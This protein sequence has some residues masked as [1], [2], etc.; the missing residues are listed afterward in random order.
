MDADKKTGS[1]GKLNK[2][3]R[4]TVCILLTILLTAWGFVHLSYMCRGYDKLMTFYGMEK[5][6]CDTV[7]IGTSTTFSGIMPMDLY[8]QQ[9]I[10]SCI[11]A[12]NMQFENSLK[13]SIR[14]VLK[15]QKPK[16]LVID[17]A[18]FVSGHHPAARGEDWHPENREL[19]IKFN[20]DSMK[21]SPGRAALVH[22]I[23][24]AVDADLPRRIY[25][26]LD[27]SRYHTNTPD[28]KHFDNAQYDIGK[29]FQYLSHDAGGKTVPE[30]LGADD[31]SSMPL[32]ETERR[33]LDELADEV[34]KLDCEVLFVFLP[35][36]C[37]GEGWQRKNYTGEYL[38]SRGFAFHDFS[39]EMEALGIDPATDFWGYNHLDSLGAAKAT[40]RIGEYLA[41]HY[42]LPDRR[43]DPA[44]AWWTK[45]L[46]SWH[47]IK[48]SND[49]YDRKT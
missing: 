37:N 20:I 18:P 35:V 1:A 42:E 17:I 49:D 29:G 27:I 30:E 40:K 25:Y 33:Y 19:F 45:E 5:D 31:G 36:Y 46:E 43:E 22:E 16:L 26:H 21:Y 32:P 34:R 2:T 7:F 44:C 10:T 4:Q 8:E 41:E 48:A 23:A 12:T 28:R 47:K 38:Q 3:V 6:S 24:D 9:G 11:Y 15:T 13:Y 14:E 39:R